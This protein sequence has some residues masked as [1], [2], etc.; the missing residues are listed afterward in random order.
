MNRLFH[1]VC[2][3]A[4][5]FCVSLQLGC[6]TGESMN[7]TTADHDHDDGFG[8]DDHHHDMNF[9]QAVEQVDTL[10]T[11][12]GDA[13]AKGDMDTAHDP[14]HEIFHALDA[15][16]HLAEDQ[17][18]SA[19]SVASLKEAVD[20]V[21][22]GYGAVDAGMH[23]EEGKS[24]DDVKAEV[25]AGLSTINSLKPSAESQL[26]PNSNWDRIAIGAD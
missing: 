18:L 9:A 19:D 24:W 21:L 13:L 16:P 6:N 17:G 3:L 20:K 1:T 7:D 4:L 14:L 12:I 25:E 2:F 23:G 22:D 10:S 26:G 15:L 8:H 5:G 11:A